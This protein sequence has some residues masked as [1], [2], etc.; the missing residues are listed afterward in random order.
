MMKRIVILPVFNEGHFIPHF[1]RNMAVMFQPTHIIMNDGLFPRG[2]ENNTT[3]TLGYKSKYT[4]EGR[5][6]F[7]LADVQKHVPLF[8]KEWPKIEVKYNKMEYRNVSTAQA[9]QMAYTCGLPSLDS[10]DIIFPLEADVFFHMKDRIKIIQ[11]IENLN[12]DEGFCCRYIRY[13]VSPEI[14]ITSTRIRRVGIKYGTGKTYRKFTEDNFTDS[15]SS[16]LSPKTD[17]IGFHYEWIRP[18]KYWSARLAQLNRDSD[19]KRGLTK[20]RN[21]II[22]TGNIPNKPTLGLERRTHSPKDHPFHIM[23]HEIFRDYYREEVH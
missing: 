23:N 17:F 6:S 16:Y 10:N 13:F 8:Q 4:T 12:P 19:F 20:D 3:M 14:V 1:L 11:H 2:P 5:W 7:D 22:S 9:Y 18:Q 21:C 15:Y